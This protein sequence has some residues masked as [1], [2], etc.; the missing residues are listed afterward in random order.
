MP[1]EFDDGHAPRDVMRE[2]Y[3]LRE[4]PF[5]ISAT[6]NPDNPGPY[7]PLMYGNQ[8]REFYEKFFLQPLQ[9]GANKQVI[10]AIWS[11]QSAAD[12]RGFGKSML[13]GEESKCVCRDFGFSVLREFKVKAE[14]AEANP[15]LA[16][17]CTF[18]QAKGVK[19]FSSAP[20]G[21]GGIHLGTGLRGRR[22]ACTRN[23]GTASP[24][25]PMATRGTR[26]RQC[27]RRCATD[28][29]PTVLSTYS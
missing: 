25:V 5:R 28:F 7:Q 2:Y 27:G 29:V 13:M 9:R 21:C 17:Y 16:G 1:L 10:G 4:Q 24:N 22:A 20:A 23:F 3:L 8:H 15:F 18:D 11:S 14:H 12:W 19:S 26:G 6:Y